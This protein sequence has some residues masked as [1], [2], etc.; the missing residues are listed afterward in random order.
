MLKRGFYISLGIIAILVVL[1][2][3]GGYWLRGELSKQ[4]NIH[5]KGKYQVDIK[6]LILNPISRSITIGGVTLKSDRP[7]GNINIQSISLSG[8]AF[9]RG[10]YSYR[11][12]SV[13][14]ISMVRDGQLQNMNLSTGRLSW[15]RGRILVS[16]IEYEYNLGNVTLSELVVDISSGELM[17]KSLNVDPIYPKEEF[18]KRTPQHR[19]WT[20]FGVDSLS[21]DGLEYDKLFKNGD[22]L[23]QRL[24]VVGATIESYKNR[25]V[26][27]KPFVK[28]IAYEALQSYP[29]HI[30]LGRVVVDDMSVRY[31]ELPPYGDKAG[32][33]TIDHLSASASGVDN[34]AEQGEYFTIDAKALLQNSGQV[35]ILIT[36][37]NNPLDTTFH[38][39]GTLGR[40]DLS[41]LNA[42]TKPLGRI[43]L[44]HGELHSIT[45]DIRGDSK[46]SYVDI[47]MLYSDLA[48]MI[49]KDRE[50]IYKD[51]KLLSSI[52]EEFFL[53]SSNPYRGKSREGIGS[54]ERDPYKSQFNYLWK[55]IFSGVKNTVLSLP[56]R[57]Q[58]R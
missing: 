16:D 34:R 13:E 1:S 36:M 48:I 31:Q 21:I 46:R 54:F 51:R 52:V 9:G 7:N 40:M 41:V 22:I 17:L 25:Q 57:K 10:R 32:S 27:Q 5:T 45:F 33:V 12:L 38:I 28:S 3:G 11:G 26:D 29:H 24:S 56:K 23:L 20:R 2:Y 37:P 39:T 14:A 49:V 50:G 47:V 30:S 42:I 55:S 43:E 15:S 58:K 6:S 19:D 44:E 4:I 35:D 18:A 53:F 8:V